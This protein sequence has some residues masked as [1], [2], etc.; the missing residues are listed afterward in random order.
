VGKTV[1]DKGEQKGRSRGEMLMGIRKEMVEKSKG[2]EI[3]R[4]GMVAGR[5]KVGKQ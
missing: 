5:V 1:G 4:E 3:V 2:V